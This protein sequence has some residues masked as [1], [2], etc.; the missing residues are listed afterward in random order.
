[1]ELANAASISS[2]N[3]P[4]SFSALPLEL[5]DHVAGLLPNRD[6]LALAQ[7][8]KGCTEVAE[9]YIWRDLHSVAPLLLCLPR[10]AWRVKQTPMKTSFGNA[11]IVPCVYLERELTR[12]DITATLK[13]RATYVRSLSVHPL[14]GIRPLDPSA[15]RRQPLYL[16]W[17]TL[18]AFTKL[19]KHKRLFK[20]VQSFHVGHSQVFYHSE[21]VLVPLMYK[22]I[23]T[24]SLACPIVDL[25][26]AVQ[27]AHVQP[28]DLILR[29]VD[30]NSPIW[31]G[32][33]RRGAVDTGV[34]GALDLWIASLKTLDMAVPMTERALPVIARGK[35]LQSLTLNSVSLLRPVEGHDL[36]SLRHLSV[37]NQP[38]SFSR[39]LLGSQV[40]EEIDLSNVMIQSAGDITQLLATLAQSHCLRHVSI[41]RHSGYKT[42]AEDGSRIHCSLKLMDLA[43]LMAHKD[44]ETLV[45]NATDDVRLTDADYGAL[46]QA[47]PALRVCKLL[48]K[49]VPHSTVPPAV[50]CT[51]H[52]L[53][54]FAVHCP[55]LEELCIQMNT[56][57]VPPLPADFRGHAALRHLHVGR[58]YGLGG[59][60][61]V[62]AYL[63]AMFPSIE[64]VHSE[65]VDVAMDF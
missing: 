9:R 64:S 5:Q 45:I 21:H 1:M 30:V 63:H 65:S 40:L 37:T 49:P 4:A 17:D 56:K 54:P 42:V 36:G 7:V 48:A 32:R 62:T 11:T 19:I 47:L 29:S 13:R 52:A 6:R 58:S 25:S 35:S 34:L 23:K 46:A 18:V 60:K 3:V 41:V 39:S 24:L 16:Q 51:L 31:G 10:D 61:A 28:T 20:Y 50:E 26:Y 2:I 8:S 57:S 44:L 14:S 15:G 53:M 38:A 33:D 59:R 12:E 43:P 22:R 27:A 55:A